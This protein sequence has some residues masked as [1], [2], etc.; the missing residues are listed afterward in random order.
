[1]TRLVDVAEAS[2]EIATTTARSAKTKWLAAVLQATD[3]DDVPAV[4]A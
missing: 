2:A 3:V 4:V 1:M